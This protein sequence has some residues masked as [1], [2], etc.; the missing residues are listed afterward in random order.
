MILQDGPYHITKV[1]KQTANHQRRNRQAVHGLSFNFTLLS[2]DDL[3][4]NMMWC[5]VAGCIAS[6]CHFVT[7]YLSHLLCTSEEALFLFV[8]F[9]VISKHLVSFTFF[10]IYQSSVH[11]AHKQKHR[12]SY[13]QKNLSTCIN[14]EK[15]KN[16]LV[17]CSKKKKMSQRR[18]KLRDVLADGG[19]MSRIVGSG[20]EKKR[21][22]SSWTS[23]ERKCHREEDDCKSHG[24]Y[25]SLKEEE[26]QGHTYT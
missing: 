16:V 4:L 14:I 24:H 25:E 5:D 23:V 13:T 9:G 21:R 1:K 2:W 20:I 3:T 12:D 10:P 26:K 22:N 8:N 19:L 15:G 7:G 11:I 6:T 17:M 18:R